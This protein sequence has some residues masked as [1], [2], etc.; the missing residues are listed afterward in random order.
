MGSANKSVTPTW[1]PGMDSG[2][3]DINGLLMQ[4]P[5]LCSR[6]AIWIRENISPSTRTYP[7][8]SYGLKHVFSSDCGVY[9]NND[10]FKAA[11]LL[12]GYGPV[13]PN[14]LNWS[15][16]IK[17]KADRAKWPA[18]E[19]VTFLWSE[20]A[21][22]TAQQLNSLITYWSE[23]LVNNPNS[24]HAAQ[25]VT[26][27]SQALELFR[28]KELTYPD[29]LYPTDMRLKARIISEVRRAEAMLYAA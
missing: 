9:V 7:S 12:E 1:F 8:T 6:L 15:Y 11:M 24:I 23:L 17:A 10:V 16:R 3:A 28:G 29:V 21:A 26:R 14:Q 27:Y 25:Q 19:R 13:D 18:T 4:A 20:T 5:E 2:Q 22:D